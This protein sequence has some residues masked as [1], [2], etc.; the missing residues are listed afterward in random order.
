[1]SSS[2]ERGALALLVRVAVFALV[3]TG[4]AE[5]W[6]RTVMPACRIP[7]SYQ[8][9]P[10]TI[11]RFDQAESGS[12]L[13]TVGRFCLRGGQW[14]VNDAG[15]NSAIDYQSAARQ[16]ATIALFGDSYVEGFLTD[17]DQHVD[18]HLSGMLPGTASYAF[19]LSGWY[20][21]Q[22]AA[23]SRYARARYQPDVLVVFVDDGD[24]ADSLRENGVV[25]PYWWQIGTQGS[26]FEEIAPTAAYRASRKAVLAKK[27]ALVN[28]LRYNAKLALPGMSGAAI[29]Q[30][31]A[32]AGQALPSEVQG[33]ANRA[34]HAW[35]QL[36]P[37]AAFMVDR[38]CADN[39]GTPIIFAVNEARYLPVHDIPSTPLA[40]DIEAIRIASRS[41]P[42][43]FFL[44]LRYPF[45]R[46][47][48]AHRVRF[49]AADGGH[50]NAYANR[51]VARTLADFI[52]E[53][54]L[55]DD[56]N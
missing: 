51:L 50:W 6:L 11:Y 23:V 16:R 4:F 47:W 10:A 36:L 25:S 43:C 2:R 55:L 24:V 42:Q 56:P 12:G 29:A 35:R 46:D 13:F 7:L 37:A 8:Q 31:E 18:A 15:W 17:A 32:S 28:Y 26:S 41:Q 21:Q 27:S 1:M 45:S 9:Q 3:F 19:G 49:E 52:T 40:P 34:A 38:L 33:P 14:R 44:D 48:A 39:P 22:Y 30:P 5:V 20:L 53:N 54:R